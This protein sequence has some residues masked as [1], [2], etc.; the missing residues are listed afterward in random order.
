MKNRTIRVQICDPFSPNQ[1][2]I[3]FYQNTQ[4]QCFG[5]F[6]ATTDVTNALYLH[7]LK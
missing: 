3:N 1:Y 2:G 7:E 5:H 4:N 6:P